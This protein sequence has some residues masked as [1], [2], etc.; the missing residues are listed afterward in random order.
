VCH[1]AIG[2]Y[3]HL[4]VRASWLLAGGDPGKPVPP[5]ALAHWRCNV[6]ETEQL[7]TGAVLLADLWAGMVQA[8]LVTRLGNAS[9]NASGNASSNVSDNANDNACAW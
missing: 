9:D 2:N 7:A 5:H 1:K 4:V 3:T 8:Q 6:V